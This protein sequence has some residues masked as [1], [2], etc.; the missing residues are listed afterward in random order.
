MLDKPGKL[1]RDKHS[2]L[3]PKLV[4]YVRKK[5]YNIGPWSEEYSIMA[6]TGAVRPKAKNH[7]MMQVRQAEILTTKHCDDITGRKPIDI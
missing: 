6:M 5:F 3:L 2:S 7:E 1:F 4:N